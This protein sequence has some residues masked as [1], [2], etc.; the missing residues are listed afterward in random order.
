[1]PGQS[2]FQTRRRLLQELPEPPQSQ[3]GIC[4]WFATPLGQKVLDS[5]RVLLA[6]VLER[7]FGY[8]ILQIGCSDQYR[9]IDDSPVGHK[10]QFSPQLHPGAR[11]AVADNAELPLPADS[12]D[13]VLIHHA[14]E[15]GE[16]SH[17][18]LREAARVLR[19]GGKLLVL[20][21]NPMGAWGVRKLFGRRAGAP[22]N[23]RFISTPRLTDWLHLLDQFVE[24]VF[25]A[26]HYLP[27]NYA[28][29]MRHADSWERLGIRI[30]LPLGGIYF[31]ISTKQV[32][33]LTPIVPRW[34]PLRPP[35][36]VI[37]ATKKVRVRIH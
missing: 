2:K 27:L 4:D 11:Q 26:G 19:P 20:G 36:R 24:N 34:R 17:R 9:L 8:H 23:A 18:L 30:N 32:A 5:E 31:V 10:I 16:N 28:S 15:F 29:L 37:P 3:S 21:F 7:L 6:P 22:W 12:M 14:L 1:M 33:T 35:V 13:V 25:Y